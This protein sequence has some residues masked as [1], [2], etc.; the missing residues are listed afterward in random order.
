M[1][2]LAMWIGLQVVAGIGWGLWMV[3]KDTREERKLK[4][5][6]NLPRDELLEI[7]LADDPSLE[8][9]FITFARV[10]GTEQATEFVTN[11]WL[12]NRRLLYLRED[13]A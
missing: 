6:V 11:H 8:S 4:A 10:I 12:I 13:L 1:K 3:Y 2:Y 5:I 9:E 7:A